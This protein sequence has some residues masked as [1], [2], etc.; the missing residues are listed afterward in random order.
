L[1]KWTKTSGREEVAQAVRNS[2]GAADPVTYIQSLLSPKESMEERR[3]KAMKE[4]EN[5]RRCEQA[6]N[7]ALAWDFG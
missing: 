5:V 7:D 3:Q 6:G 2:S 4:M 1:G